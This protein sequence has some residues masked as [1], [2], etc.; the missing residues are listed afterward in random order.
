M[1]QPHPRWPRRS[2]NDAALRKP[3]PK[4][5]GVRMVGEH[6]GDVIW[7]ADIDFRWR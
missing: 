4:A 6:V 1:V 2:P 7:L 3:P 5:S